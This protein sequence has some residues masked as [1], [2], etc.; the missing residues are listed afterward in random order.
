MLTLPT[1]TLTGGVYFAYQHFQTTNRCTIVGANQR[2]KHSCF[3]FYYYFFFLFF[4]FYFNKQKT[5]Q[6]QQN[7]T[8]Y[9][10]IIIKKNEKKVKINL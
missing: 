6:Q 2:Q 4:I 1:I 8:K 3:S 5:Q 10:I 9:G 7:L